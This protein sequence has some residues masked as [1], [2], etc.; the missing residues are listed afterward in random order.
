MPVHAPPVE[1]HEQTF[2]GH[3]LAVVYW[4]H[5]VG[6]PVHGTAEPDHVQPYAFVVEQWV[7][8]VRELQGVNVPPHVALHVHP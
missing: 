1:L 5:W 4:L 2:D 7:L 3:V 8:S 6:V